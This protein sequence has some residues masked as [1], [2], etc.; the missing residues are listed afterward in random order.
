MRLR[1]LRELGVAD[2]VKTCSVCDKPLKR[3]AGQNLAW[4][5]GLCYQHWIQT[6]EGK[7]NRR[8]G[9]IKNDIWGVA[10]FGGDPPQYFTRIKAALKAST[11]KAGRDNQPLFIVWS[12]G[13]VT[14][15][16][17]LTSRKA[18]GV[19]PEDGDEMLEGFEE[20]LSEVPDAQKNW[21]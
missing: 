12:D 9:Q 6:P 7:Q 5:A 13:R 2:P 14:L 1:R 15:H 8:K 4:S 16:L 3:G 11:V 20:F 17:G 18:V 10:F 19:K 21:F